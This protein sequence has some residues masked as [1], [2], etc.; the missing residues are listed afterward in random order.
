[1]QRPRA[2]S[3]SL[4]KRRRRRLACLLPLAVGIQL[5]TCSI[6]DVTCNHLRVERCFD[7]LREMP[8]AMREDRNAWREQPG[9]GVASGERQR[10]SATGEILKS[11]AG[12]SDR[13]R[14]RMRTARNKLPRILTFNTVFVRCI[15]LAFDRRDAPVLDLRHREFL[16]RL[17]PCKLLVVAVAFGD[18]HRGVA[19]P[20]AARLDVLVVIAPGGEHGAKLSLSAPP[21]PALDFKSRHSVGHDGAL[22]KE[23]GLPAPRFRRPRRDAEVRATGQ[24]ALC[25]AQ[26]RDAPGPRR[27]AAV[28]AFA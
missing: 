26:H 15:S 6:A 27:V 4:R 9:K 10:G 21:V 22:A 24:Q 11:P 1:M 2:H 23:H 3:L 8:H 7:C 18:G 5:D 25:G 12:G 17:K 14:P 19:R 20:C 16:F 28:D 13:D